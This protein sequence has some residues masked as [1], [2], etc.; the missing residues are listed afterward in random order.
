MP[1]SDSSGLSTVLWFFRKIYSPTTISQRTAG[2]IVPSVG[3]RSQ[4]IAT[5]H[6]SR[7][8]A[9]GELARP[10]G[11]A[12]HR[13]GHVAGA[14]DPSIDPVRLGL[15]RAAY[16]RLGEASLGGAIGVP[17]RQGAEYN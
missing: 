3:A 11:R 8:F 15:A 13:E 4:G 1:L 17:L 10:P 9:A 5:A 6:N 2:E 12:R 7:R 14:R 16:D